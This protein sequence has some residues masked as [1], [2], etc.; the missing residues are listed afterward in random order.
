MNTKIRTLIILLAVIVPFV[1]NGS[2]RSTGAMPNEVIYF[3]LVLDEPRQLLYG[4]DMDGGSIHVISMQTLEVVTTVSVGSD[5][6]GIDISPDGSWLAVALSGQED[7]AIID[8]NTLTVQTRMTH[9]ATSGLNQPYDVVFGRPG[10]LYSVGN[11]GSSG[12]D[13]VHAYDTDIWLE[14]SHSIEDMRAAPRLAMTADQNNLYVSQVSF[15]PQK[16]YQFNVSGYTP[17]QTAVAPHGPV[18]VR[19]LCVMPDNRVFTSRGQVWSAVNH[20]A[21]DGTRQRAGDRMLQ[22]GTKSVYYQRVADHHH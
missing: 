17:Y 2:A 1:M 12:L 9:Q 6:A 19:T 21:G 8:L 13:Y 5:P 14:M 15:S 11:P 4:S 18:A 7:I 10:R 20:S 22:A 3:D 16:I